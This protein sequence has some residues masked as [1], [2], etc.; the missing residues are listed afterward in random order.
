MIKTKLLTLIVSINISILIG[1]N[2][3]YIPDTLSGTSFTLNVQTGTKQFFGTNNTPTF[4]YNGN[5]L[6]PTLIIKKD[7]SITLNVKNNLTQKTTVHWHGFHVSPQNDGGPHQI[8]NAGA[9]W[10]PSFKMRN[11]A[12]TF[13]Y[14]PHGEGKTEIQ[15]ST[16]SP[17]DKRTL[18]V[19]YG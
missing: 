2:P 8:I 10:S 12:A 9:T 11:E 13:W 15:I 18:F 5:F 14:H 17:V 1:Q 16:L 4:G 3:L 7:D 19:K 6:G